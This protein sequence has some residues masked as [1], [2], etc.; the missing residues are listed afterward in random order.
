M[1]RP[2]ACVPAALLVFVINEQEEFLLLRHPQRP[3]GRVVNGAL[4][5][6]ETLADGALRE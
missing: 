3:A 5:A 1:G 4:E 6:N 2:F